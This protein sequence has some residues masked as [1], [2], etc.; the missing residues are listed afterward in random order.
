MG[1]LLLVFENFRLFNLHTHCYFWRNGSEEVLVES[2]GSCVT[3]ARVLTAATVMYQFRC[4]GKTGNW[5]ATSENGYH[6]AIH[7]SEGC[8]LVSLPIET[9]IIRAIEFVFKLLCANVDVNYIQ[10]GSVREREEQPFV[11]FF[12]M[13]NSQVS[14]L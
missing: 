5:V 14:L 6:S 3:G 10:S 13:P 11:S 2:R 12:F 4:A 8:A 1:P 9:K 7:R